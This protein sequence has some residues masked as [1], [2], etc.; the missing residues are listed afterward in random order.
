MIR[1]LIP[2]ISRLTS[3]LQ[4]DGTHK[5]SISTLQ[6][7]IKWKYTKYKEIYAGYK[8]DAYTSTKFRL[9]ISQIALRS[10][11]ICSYLL[12]CVVVTFELFSDFANVYILW[13][14]VSI[15]VEKQNLLWQ[16]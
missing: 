8:F 5:R 2:S 9:I 12:I 10:H 13:G 7:G 11:S 14:N 1:R 16:V 15:D 3:S 6:L 4:T